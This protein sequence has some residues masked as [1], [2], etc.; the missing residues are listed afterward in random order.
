[1]SLV[2]YFAVLCSECFRWKILHLCRF[3]SRLHFET[4]S[5]ILNGVS[6]FQDRVF[7][8]ADVPSSNVSSSLKVCCFFFVPLSFYTVSVRNLSPLP[9]PLLVHPLQREDEELQLRPPPGSLPWT[10]SIVFV[11]SLR[12]RPWRFYYTPLLLV[13]LPQLGCFHCLSLLL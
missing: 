4:L 1:V 2:S 10:S 12:I 7:L 5:F 11:L 3:P 9:L 6:L 13:S 8:E